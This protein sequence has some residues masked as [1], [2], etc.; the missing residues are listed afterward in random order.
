MS[1]YLPVESIIYTTIISSFETKSIWHMNQ[2]EHGTFDKGQVDT[3]KTSI[4][5]LFIYKTNA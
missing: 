4:V 3:S 2:N 5:H 1:L